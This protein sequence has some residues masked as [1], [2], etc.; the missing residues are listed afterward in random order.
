MRSVFIPE[1]F[2]DTTNT[3][4]VNTVDVLVV[5]SER[6]K[7]VATCTDTYEF[8]TVAAPRVV[9]NSVCFSVDVMLP[10]GHIVPSPKMTKE[11]HRVFLPNLDLSSWVAPFKL[12]YELIPCLGGYH[13]DIKHDKNFKLNSFTKRGIKVCVNKYVNG[14]HIGIGCASKQ[15]ALY[16]FITSVGGIINTTPIK[17]YI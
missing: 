3:L 4:A 5:L 2:Y 11:L 10:L 14:K 12:Q 13:F 15:I 6:G 9:G 17:H 7:A 8:Y 1:M 16:L